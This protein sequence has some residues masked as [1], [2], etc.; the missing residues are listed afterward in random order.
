MQ[1]ELQPSNWHYSS[2]HLVLGSSRA[3]GPLEEN[4][5]LPAI[6]FVDDNLPHELVLA[7]LGE[8]HGPEEPVDAAQEDDAEADDAVNPI[9][10]G[11]VLVLV[12]GGRGDEGREDEVQ[13]AEEEEDNHG[14]GGAEG[15]VPAERGAIEV[16]VGEAGGDECVDDGQ[17]VGDEAG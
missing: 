5:A 9:G 10:K 8:D 6:K 2:Q 16:E 12:R 4:I 15:R 3:N 14:E 13:V 17:G 7:D 1:K 11:R